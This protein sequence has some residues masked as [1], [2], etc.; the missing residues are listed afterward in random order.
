VTVIATNIVGSSVSSAAGYGAVILTNPQPP[1]LLANNPAITSASVIAINWTPPSV[2]GG[3][4]VI[5][6]RVSWD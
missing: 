2:V 4:P 1:S 6:Y 3:T 5:D